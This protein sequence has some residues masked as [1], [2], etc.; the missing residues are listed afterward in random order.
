MGDWVRSVDR[1]SWLPASAQWPRA[2]HRFGMPVRGYPLNQ[3]LPIALIGEGPGKDESRYGYPFVG[4]SGQEVDRHLARVGLSRELCLVTNY[5]WQ[6][7]PEKGE[8]GSINPRLFD[9]LVGAQPA[10]I[11]TLGRHSTRYFLGDVDMEAVHGIP[12]A[13]MFEDDTIGG[14][15]LGR[16][17]ILP[18]YHPA[19]GMH[20]VELSAHVQYDFDALAAT[21]AGDLAPRAGSVDQWPEPC[22]YEQTDDDPWFHPDDPPEVVAKTWTSAGVAIDT[23]GSVARPWCLS[24]SHEPGLAYV[25]RAAAKRMIAGFGRA[26]RWAAQRIDG[27][28]V[29]LHNSMH[30]LP[31]LQVLGIDL[32]EWGIPFLDTMVLAYHLCVEPQGLKALAFRHCGMRMD[33]YADLVGPYTHARAMEYLLQIACDPVPF[34][35]RPAYVDFEIKGRVQTPKM[36]TPTPINKRAAKIVQDVSAGKVN[37]DGELTDPYKRWYQIEPE[38]RAIAEARYGVLEE[39]TLDD[40]PLST[41]VRYAARDADATR[42][43]GPILLARHQAVFGVAA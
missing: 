6:P 42:R 35:R 7:P 10:V 40:V 2:G 37:K 3:Q 17:I 27:F 11:M 8:L 29:W 39:A 12:H 28:R 19:A 13:P 1:P 9:E 24:Y 36:H 21:F 20:N 16:P 15:L 5:T 34:P 26:L 31:V 14:K 30:D 43:L 25:L 4:A 38:D 41:A 18:G 22:Y 33:S 32:V 23:E